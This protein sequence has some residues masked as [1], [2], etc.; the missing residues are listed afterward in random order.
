[1]KVFTK[2]K[3]KIKSFLHLSTVDVKE[4]IKSAF[5]EDFGEKDVELMV[6]GLAKRLTPELQSSLV[7]S[8]IKYR[9]QEIKE[10][11]DKLL[12]LRQDRHDLMTAILEANSEV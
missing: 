3:T 9:N 5:K 8:L 6:N 7:L 1:M 4:A 12:N 11:Q 2:I 10:T